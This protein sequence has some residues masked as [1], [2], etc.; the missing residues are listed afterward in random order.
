LTDVKEIIMRLDYWINAWKLL[1]LPY[2]FILSY[3]V[4]RDGIREWFYMATHGTYGILWS[5]KGFVAPD[6]R[7]SVPLIPSM[8]VLSS[9]YL[10]NYLIAPT[11]MFLSDPIVMH[12]SELMYWFIIYIIG[13]F[14]HFGSD[15]QKYYI[16]QNNTRLITDGFFY[17]LKHPNYLGEA[18]IY[19]SFCGISG[20]SWSYIV[21]IFQMCVCWWPNMLQKEKSLSRHPEW[22][23]YRHRCIM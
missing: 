13:V 1:T 9:I 22:E 2:L 15:I 12:G 17:Y 3:L 23:N 7:F 16:L 11:V 8:A 14:L 18:L 6:R 21:L 5:L 20:V 19:V 10:M 4:G